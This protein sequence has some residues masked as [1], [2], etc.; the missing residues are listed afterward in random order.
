MNSYTLDPPKSETTIASAALSTPAPV[1]AH[2]YLPS[3][4][5]Y[6]QASDVQSDVHKIHD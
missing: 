4:Y 6:L 2:I 5:Q 1:S 3:Y